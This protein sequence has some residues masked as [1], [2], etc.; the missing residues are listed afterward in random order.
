[1]VNKTIHIIDNATDVVTSDTMIFLGPLLFCLCMIY[2]C[3][4]YKLMRRPIVEPQ[5]NNYARTRQAIDKDIW[6]FSSPPSKIYPRPNPTGSSDNL[7]CQELSL[8]KVCDDSFSPSDRK[9][10]FRIKGSEESRVATGPGSSSN[11][12]KCND[13]DISSSHISLTSVSPTKIDSST[14][15]VLNGAQHVKAPSKVRSYMLSQQMHSSGQTDTSNNTMTF[16]GELGV[17]MKIPSVKIFTRTLALK[18][19]TPSEGSH[20]ITVHRVSH[21]GSYKTIQLPVNNTSMQYD[22]WVSPSMPYGGWVSPDEDFKILEETWNVKSETSVDILTQV[23]PSRTSHSITFLKSSMDKAH[24][25]SKDQVFTP[26]SQNDSKDHVFS[27]GCENNPEKG[28]D[29]LKHEDHKG[30][31]ESVIFIGSVV[32]NSKLLNS[33]ASVSK[34]ESNAS[35]HAGEEEQRKEALSEDDDST[36]LVPL[37]KFG[38]DPDNNPKNAILN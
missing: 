27:P 15:K 4:D 35:L 19:F 9:L 1:M 33:G 28:Q 37:L 29:K 16:E 23:E 7:E 30:T 24:N 20:P 31:Q 22:G 3:I 18:Q 11:V 12:L 17:D 36:L 38:A 8:V 21:S 13:D 5:K 26:D 10:L 25:D 6:A 14:I 34:F 32:S 2:K